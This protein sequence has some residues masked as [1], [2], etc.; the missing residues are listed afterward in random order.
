MYDLDPIALDRLAEAM[1]TGA[2]VFMLNLLR[3]HPDRGRER[4]FQ[5]YVPAFRAIMAEQGHD[6]IEPVWS[7]AVACALAGPA[8]EAWDAV[9]IVRYP[10]PEAF[11]AIVES[12]A[13]RERAL[14][15]RL[16]AL[17]D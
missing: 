9:A 16:A 6:G 17:V 13:Y 1:P 4:Y 3:F 10:N 7:G 14:P 2:P 8:S 5:A 11:R 12:D 15:H